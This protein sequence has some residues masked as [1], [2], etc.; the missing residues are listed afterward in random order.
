MTD[1]PLPGLEPDTTL[2]IDTA[3]L[4][5]ARHNQRRDRIRYRLNNLAGFTSRLTDPDCEQLET[6]LTHLEHNIHELHP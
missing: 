5:R 3:T 4:T 2:Y 6:L 1:H